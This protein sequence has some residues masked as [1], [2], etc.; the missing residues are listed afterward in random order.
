MVKLLP[1]TGV[2]LFPV[3]IS[4]KLSDCE[5]PEVAL[6]LQYAIWIN[7][8]TFVDD[9]PCWSLEGYLKSC[10]SVVSAFHNLKGMK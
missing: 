5:L 1:T 10:K 3:A 9:I 7:M 2:N 6:G 8:Q 4:R